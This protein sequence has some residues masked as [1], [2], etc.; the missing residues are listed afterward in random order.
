ME[1][2]VVATTKGPVSVENCNGKEGITVARIVRWTVTH[3]DTII[4]TS[5]LPEEL[6]LE[7]TF[8]LQAL[9]RTATERCD[10]VLRPEFNFAKVYQQSAPR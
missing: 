5:Q 3:R 10:N 1:A 7:P 4:R 8:Q 6:L 9:P 2:P